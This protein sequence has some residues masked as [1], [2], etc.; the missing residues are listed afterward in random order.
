MICIVGADGFL[1]SYIQQ[2][3]LTSDITEPVLCL[4][5]G[6]KSSDFSPEFINL[7]FDLQNEKDIAEAVNIMSAYDD[8][9]II[10]LAAVHNPDIIK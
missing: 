7:H 3:I 4:N 10:F 9:R 1:G 8:I 2:H 6:T 5:H